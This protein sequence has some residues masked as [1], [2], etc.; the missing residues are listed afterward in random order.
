MDVSSTFPL[1][2]SPAVRTS[3]ESRAMCAHSTLAGL[4]KRAVVQIDRCDQLTHYLSKF[5]TPSSATTATSNGPS[6]EVTAIDGYVVS[7]HSRGVMSALRCMWSC[8]QRMLLR[9]T[10][11]A[12]QPCPCNAQELYILG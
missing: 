9:S 12:R 1:D 2:L 11:A 4:N 7:G 8:S 3:D 6:T 5:S 10:Y